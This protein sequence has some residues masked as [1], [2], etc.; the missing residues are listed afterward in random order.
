MTAEI[1]GKTVEAETLDELRQIARQQ[2]T[3]RWIYGR[4]DRARFGFCNDP[5]CRCDGF[6][7]YEYERN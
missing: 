3:E 4:D 7:L 6:I 2:S 1:N 5:N